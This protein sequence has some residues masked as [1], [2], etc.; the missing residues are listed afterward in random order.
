MGKFDNKTISIYGLG[1]V[2]FNIGQTLLEKNEK[3]VVNGF[4]I[5]EEKITIA[6]ESNAISN[7]MKSYVDSIHNSEIIILSVP[8]SSVYE[9]LETLRDQISEDTIIIDICSSKRAVAEWADELL[10]NNEI[11]GIYPFIHR[12]SILN[13]N[14]GVISYKNT[15]DNSTECVNL[16]VSELEGMKINLD[17]A[18]H[19]SYIALTEAMP[20]MIIS[21]LL[22]ISNDSSSWKEVYKYFNND[23]FKMFSSPLDN[24]PVKI[25]SSISTN[26]DLLLDWIKLYIGELVKIQKILERNSEDEIAS[27][28]RKT[29][30]DRLK[31]INNIDP[32]LDSGENIIPS[33]SENILSLFIGSRAAR[34]FSKSKEIDKDKYGFEKRI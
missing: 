8:T 27:V 20:M 30:E 2:G 15:K 34:F 33:S 19:D 11:I 6:K 9:I 25:F 29:W 31:I 7:K 22:S 5:K 32:G 3:L 26:N 24:D 16:F 4:D 14:W 1:S 23:D 12:D 13:N 10:P 17:L 21:S 28:I 18:E